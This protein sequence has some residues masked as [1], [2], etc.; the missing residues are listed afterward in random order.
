[1]FCKTTCFVSIVFLVANIFVMF[2]V[3]KDKLKNNFIKLLNY[4]QRELYE[5]LIKERRNI[6]FQGYALGLLLSLIYLF[7]I[8]QIL[9]KRI[10]NIL[11]VCSVGFI[12]FI[13]NY[14]YYILMKKSTY[15]IEHLNNKEQT[16]AWL[17][18]YR[19]MQVKYHLGLLLGII[20]SMIFVA[21]YK[22]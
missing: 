7:Y 17:D 18:I 19:T 20:A 13:T 11:L 1:M 4:Q 5:S 8:K 12:V 22:C 16:K 3:D 2:N 9:G 14:L 6:Y 10:N 15:M 21:S